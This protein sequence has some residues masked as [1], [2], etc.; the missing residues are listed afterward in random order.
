MGAAL[1]RQAAG[2]GHQ[3]GSPRTPGPDRPRA[4][5]QVHELQIR[6]LRVR[7]SQAR[8]AVIRSATVRAR[9]GRV[10]AAR[11]EAGVT[12]A[13]QETRVTA[14]RQGT[15]I[16]SRP[17]ASRPGASRPGASRQG[18]SRPGAVRLTRRGR[19]VLATAAILAVLTAVALI[20]LSA[21]GG[22]QASDRGTSPG[23]PYRGMTQV[24]VRPGQTLWSIASAAEPAADPR[25]VVQ[26]II[27][28]N[29]LSGAVIQAGQLLWVPRN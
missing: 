11:Q 27:D 2:S 24:V 20:W 12:D 14:A 16:V 8:A 3:A 25:I 15:R 7:H 21:A 18:A 28:A 5:Y 13:R 26:Q 19:A 4:R 22:A 10:T 1:A 9:A 23:S 6:Q 29:A 17:G